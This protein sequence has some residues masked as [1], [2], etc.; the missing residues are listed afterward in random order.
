[1]EEETETAVLEDE[2]DNKSR[3]EV[4]SEGSYDF[5]QLDDGDFLA[6]FDAVRN[7][8]DDAIMGDFEF[9]ATD[10]D[11][12]EGG[13]TD[14]DDLE[15]NDA[16]IERVSMD[17]NAPKS[18]A[19]GSEL[20]KQE[21]FLQRGQIPFYGRA[22]ELASIEH[23]VQRV[24]LEWM[25]NPSELLWLV[26]PKGVGKSTLL[27]HARATIPT[28]TANAAIWLSSSCEP[29]R[30]A[31]PPFAPISECL[32]ELCRVLQQR[33]GGNSVWK[34]RL[35]EA[36]GG[37]GPLLATIVPGLVPLLRLSKPIDRRQ[38]LSF[39][40]NTRRRRQRL[41]FAVR[42][43]LQAVSEYHPIVMVIENIQYAGEDIL[44]IL[45]QLITTEHLQ[46]FL[47]LGS[48]DDDL[49]LDEDGSIGAITEW[50]A[51]LDQNTVEGSTMK[52]TTI[53]LLPFDLQGVEEILSSIFSKNDE[54]IINDIEFID[55]VQ[56]LAK[57]IF[58]TTKG[59]VL[60]MIAVLKLFHEKKLLTYKVKSGKDKDK[61][62][63]SIGKEKVWDWNRKKIK[64]QIKTWKSETDPVFESAIGVIGDRLETLPDQIK[65][66]LEAM[67]AL[68]LN[69]FVTNDLFPIL[70][71]AWSTKQVG[72]KC[73]ISSQEELNSLLIDAMNQGWIKT[74]KGQRPGHY[75]FV[76][77]IVRKAA[78]DRLMPS[79]K[80]KRLQI[81]FQIGTESLNALV[82]ERGD[83]RER[84]KFL[85]VNQLNVGK[86]VMDASF[87]VQICRSN[88]EVAELAIQKTAFRTAAACLERT[89]EI[90]SFDDNHDTERSRNTK[91]SRHEVTVRS[92]LTLAR[93]LSC[94][95][96]LDP[97]KAKCN[98]ILL[99]SQNLKDHVMATQVYTIVLMQEERAE[100]AVQRLIETLSEMGE[101][102]PRENVSSVIDR[103]VRNLRKTLRHTDNKQLLNPP[104]MQDRKMLDIMLLLANLA[105]ISLH[106]KHMLYV[107][108]AMIRMMH[109]SLKFGF[110]RQYPMAFS[111]FGVTLAKKGAIK[112]AHRMG[113]VA[114]KIARPGD[115]YGGEAVTL[116]HWHISH[117]KRTY[118]R[119][120]EPVLKT[121]NAQI[122]SGDFQHVDFSISTYVQYHLASGYDLERLSDNLQ[123]F[124]GIYSDYTLSDDWHIIVPQQAVAN[125]LGETVH[126]L[127]FFGDTIEQQ[128]TQI[129]QW[130]E[131]GK[132][133]A[134]YYFNFLRLYV[135]FFFHD[136]EIA[137][138][139]LA[140]LTKPAEGVWIPWMVFLE[141]Y[142]D[143]QKLKSVKGKKRKMLREQIEEKKNTLIDWYNNGAPNTSAMVSILEA[144]F[145]I[146]RE[147]GK[148]LAAM[149][150]QEI[151]DEAIDAASHNGAT[152][153][154]AFACERAGLHLD[155]MGA[156]GYSAQYL[157][158]AHKVYDKWHAI[159][160]VIDLE[161]SFADKLQVSQRTQRAASAYLLRNAN[162]SPADYKIGGGQGEIKTPNLMKLVRKAGRLRKGFKIK[163]LLAKKEKTEELN[164]NVCS[165]QNSP[166]HA[167]HRL[168]LGSPKNDPRLSLFNN[169]GSEDTDRKDIMA[170]G[171][172][173][174]SRR[175]LKIPKGQLKLPF[176]GR[177]KQER[178]ST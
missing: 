158:R 111:L 85:A 151:Y 75:Q 27:Q 68:Q 124:D 21:R 12:W 108:L 92:Y 93:M 145:L 149:K 106:S 131:E 26:G 142:F 95:E 136:Y 169:Q 161:T 57:I 100:E 58:G 105:E 126:P 63:D 120:L 65:F 90:L 129:Q 43:F 143:I 82:E 171:S 46:N 147:T 163:G 22:A 159:A 67:S 16:A 52:A 53:S 29:T 177:K 24:S 1:M 156:D 167:K 122:D 133:E 69:R 83:D 91:V 96:R 146:A 104:R 3:Y 130:E 135:A 38:L 174:E 134:L 71:V 42:D 87:Q 66:V 89:I 51:S 74:Q 173:P 153:L 166:I 41:G 25:E 175:S 178:S 56:D 23:A 48:H 61:D 148:G 88:L 152:H 121:Y 13:S 40:A 70:Q 80:E 128:E 170:H 17:R 11:F 2:E 139:C 132:T 109:L 81:H 165:Q 54:A 162:M 18:V 164:S 115:F 138:E 10:A 77:D 20:T 102:F 59:N 172:K 72:R 107:D 86:D 34:S 119:N 150:V 5:E 14:E 113:Q 140:N 101:T 155:E 28:N 45:R 123:L 84:M 73:P 103:E 110:C 36:L 78:Y 160:K 176:G 112:E 137:E 76:H 144:E 32:N 94:C 9:G 154:E 79:D 47:L 168:S 118:T 99:Y 8:S 157:G 44:Q 30:L 33:G 19:V 31:V 117:W 98:E 114:E 49:K 37:E 64:K 7:K 39:D 50:K 35:E 97:A 62:D 55:K 116:F 4:G 6:D 141:C 15:T 127:L 60:W 125:M